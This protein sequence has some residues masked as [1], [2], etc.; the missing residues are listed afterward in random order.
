MQGRKNC[1]SRIQFNIL[2]IARSEQ[3]M[4]HFVNNG[5]VVETDCYYKDLFGALL[6]LILKNSQ[7][8]Y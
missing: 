5:C 2:D 3:G 8:F 1:V 4:K 6:V 7:L